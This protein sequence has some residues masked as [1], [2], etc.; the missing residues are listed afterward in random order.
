MDYNSRHTQRRI[1]LNGSDADNL[2]H[3][4]LIIAH[5][6]KN[7]IDKLY[8]ASPHGRDYQTAPENYFVLDRQLWVDQVKEVE[9]IRRY[10]EESALVLH[11]QKECV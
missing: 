3:Q 2:I 4:Q 5:A 9:S 1:N 8:E 10:A 6:A 11:R 7:L